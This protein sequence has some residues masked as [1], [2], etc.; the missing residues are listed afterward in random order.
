MDKAR[1]RLLLI[2]FTVGLQQ[3]IIGLYGGWCSPYLAILVADD[4]PIKITFDQATWISS[5]WKLGS[6]L[7]CILSILSVDIVGRKSIIL[8]CLIPNVLSW[9][10][11]AWAS[12][13]ND[14]YVARFVGGITSG[15]MLMVGPT[16]LSECSPPLLR[17]SLS[18][19]YFLLSLFGCL[20]GYTLGAF[21][22][23]SRY[24][25][26]AIG[27]S[28][29]QAA[30]FICLP[31]TPYHLIRKKRYVDASKALRLLR[32]CNNIR[33]ELDSIMRSVESEPR[34]AGICVILREI[35]IRPGGKREFLIG[36]SLMAAH[37]LS[38]LQL[39]V[40]Y[41][42]ILFNAMD[43]PIMPG[44]YLSIIL[45]IVYICGVVVYMYLVD[46]VGRKPMCLISTTVVI[47]SAITAGTYFFLSSY[48]MKG[49]DFSNY[50]V[51]PVI[52]VF[53]YV[54]GG[55]LGLAN[56]SITV[57]SEI[58]PM[59]SKVTCVNFCSIISSIC[60]FVLLKS[61]SLIIT[62]L[63]L[64]FMFWIFACLN[65]FNL[66]LFVFF[67]PA[68]INKGLYQISDIPSFNYQKL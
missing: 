26:V 20:M 41:A 18:V 42:G 35:L 59:Y 51:I 37:A 29:F 44:K 10:I 1:N 4:S 52:A 30:I 15:T 56:V 58:F 68:T 34:N 62:R 11:T 47:I 64:D 63:G 21:L 22:E 5:L 66:S 2:T 61:W 28:I 3:I 48:A 36:T 9:V 27:L 57:V 33:E 19:Y 45:M 46:L 16:Y 24:S 38:G 55:S 50:T 43:N 49:Y 8:F 13:V 54:L 12:S 67:V 14:F 23:I 7:G 31:E 60:S 53:F 40:T 65:I 39:L 17:K 6:I 25:Y 32:G